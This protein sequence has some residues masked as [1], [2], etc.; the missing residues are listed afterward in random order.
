MHTLKQLNLQAAMSQEAF[1]QWTARQKTKLHC[2]N[3]HK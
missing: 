2:V 3:N 1:A